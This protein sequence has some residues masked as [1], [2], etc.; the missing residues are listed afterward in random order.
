MK[1]SITGKCFLKH[2]FL[3][4]RTS[5]PWI[6]KIMQMAMW[7]EMRIFIHFLTLENTL[8]NSTT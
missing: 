2:F 6:K 7:Y 3:K 8:K 5:N 4:S 1:V